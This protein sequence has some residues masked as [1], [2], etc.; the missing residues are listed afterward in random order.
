MHLL[1]IS[2]SLR[3]RSSNTTLLHAAGRVLPVETTFSIYNGLPL[4]P[5]FNPDLDVEPALPSVDTFRRE[6]AHADAVLISSPEYAH[7]VPGTLKN[8]LD[9]TV[10]SG[11]FVGKPVAIVNTSVQSQ[12]VTD[13]LRETLSVMMARVIVS[14][15]LPLSFRPDNADE[16]LADEAACAA[17]R[18]AVSALLQAVRPA[19]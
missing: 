6:L 4:L 5:A 16:L 9:W 8:A 7:G 12:F 18:S 1:A 10:G 19:A 11:E 17:L 14:E 15:A 2:G 3:A 13:Q